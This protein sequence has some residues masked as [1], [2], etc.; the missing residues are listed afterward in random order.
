MVTIKVTL[1]SNT[2]VVEKILYLWL[3][4]IISWENTCSAILSYNMSQ[5][6][7]LSLSKV[8]NPEK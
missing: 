6:E 7:Q 4:S 2:D 1:V 3:A 8:A 5:E